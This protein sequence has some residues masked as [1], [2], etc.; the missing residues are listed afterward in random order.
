MRFAACRKNVNPADRAQLTAAY[1]ASFSARMSEAKPRPTFNA[2]LPIAFTLV[3]RK[4]F[5]D[6]TPLKQRTA[7][8]QTL[9]SD[10]RQVV[11][12]VP[13]LQ[14][15]ST[16]A[17]TLG[18]FFNSTPTLTLTPGICFHS[19]MTLDAGKILFSTSTLTPTPHKNLQ[20]PRL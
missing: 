14:S 8:I 13:V 12:F 10:L 19:T 7:E 2:C 3:Y 15:R 18:L 1:F 4:C 9:V 17:L 16:L 5:L 20:L 6:H 11:A